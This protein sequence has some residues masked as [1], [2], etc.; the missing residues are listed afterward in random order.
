MDDLRL[1]RAEE[2]GADDPEDLPS[3]HDLRLHTAPRASL[4]KGMKREGMGRANS[5]GSISGEGVYMD[6][7]GDYLLLTTPEG[8]YQS[9]KHWT[10]TLFARERVHFVK[11]LGFIRPLRGPVVPGPKTPP[12][13]PL[14]EGLEPSPQLR[15]HGDPGTGIGSPVREKPPASPGKSRLNSQ[16]K[17]KVQKPK[18]PIGPPS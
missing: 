10:S 9:S 12:F 17:M 6:V 14:F 3:A 8:T 5:S 13:Q 15:Q 2:E 7:D 4:L 18:A 11:T 1:V 16:A